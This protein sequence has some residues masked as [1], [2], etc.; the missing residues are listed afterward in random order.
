MASASNR[1]Q[2]GDYLLEQKQ[3]ANVS[4]YSTYA[5]YAQPL[6]T[7][8]PGN[9]LLAG[10]LAY[11]SLSRNDSDIESFLFGIGS[12]NLVKPKE[13]T[14]IDLKKI[15][16]LNVADRTPLLLPDPLVIQPGQRQRFLK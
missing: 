8:F 16:S 14:L 7:H 10:R 1:N 5:T 9:G 2:P 4:E 12:T 11:G 3:N 15:S 6:Q 13:P